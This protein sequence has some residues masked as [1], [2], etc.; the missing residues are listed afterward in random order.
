M[1]FE[2]LGHNL[3]KFILRSNYQGI[4]I[5]NVKILIKQVLQGLSYLHNVCNIIH[6][7]IKPENI[8]VCVKSSQVS[9]MAAQATFC[10]KHGLKMP[11]SAVSAAPK[12]LMSS[13]EAKKRRA[14]KR[15][16]RLSYGKEILEDK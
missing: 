5:E 10:H 11:E 14:R 9:K 16:K 1:V 7:D 6:T 12:E 2:V 3:L 4:P 8:L 15:S 13:L